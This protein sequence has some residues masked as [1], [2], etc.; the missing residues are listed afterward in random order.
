MEILFI[1]MIFFIGTVFGSFFTLAVYRIP[2][3]KNITH[4][5]SFCPN[6]EHRLEFKDLI[7]VFSYIFLKGK[8]R[9]CGEKVRPRYLILEILSGTVFVL[10]YISVKINI[11]GISYLYFGINYEQTVEKLIYLLAFT[12][13]YI[14]NAII[15]GID[16]EYM[17]INRK[18]L[19]FGILTQILYMIYLNIL[20]QQ[21]NYIIY[22]ITLIFLLI[23]TVGVAVFGD[24]E[25]NKNYIF[26]NILYLIYITKFIGIKNLIILIPILILIIVFLSLKNGSPRTTTPTKNKYKIL[27]GF[28]IGIS[29]IITT[30]ISN[31]VK[32]YIE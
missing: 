1:I 12:C 27:I 23:S 20:G 24:P 29:A 18:V 8:C 19:I 5:R 21:Y 22:L 4:E 10:A 6:C 26:Q 3:G 14:T 7:P 16:K 2:L 31:F 28:S 32:N 15:I 11:L 30:L 13:F 25:K 17:Q 9:Y